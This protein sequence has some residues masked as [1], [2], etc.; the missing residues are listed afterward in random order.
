MWLRR[1]DSGGNMPVMAWSSI[2][3]VLFDAHLQSTLAAVDAA[4]ASA[5]CDT[6]VLQAGDQRLL[7]QD[8]QASPFRSNP[9]FA[10]LVPAP[11]A[12]GSLLRI[13]RGEAP[14]LLFVAPDDYWH[15]P[16]A[17][18]TSPWT[19]RFR[20]RAMASGEAALAE[21]Q[22]PTSGAAWIG[23]AAPADDRWQ[24]NPPQLLAQLEQARCRKSAYEISCLREAT[25]VA[26]AGHLAAERAFRAGRS[27]F[28]IHLAYLGAVRQ[29]DEELPYHSIIGLNEHAATLHYQLRE[30]QPPARSLSLLI[31]AGASCRGYGSDITRTWAM[32]PGTFATLVDGMHVLQQELCQAVAPGVDWRELHLTAHRLVAELLRQAGVLKISA[33]EAVERGIS[34]T[35][36]PHGLG[37]LLGVQVHDV[38]GFRATADSPPIPR[39]PGHPALRLTRKLEAGMVVTVEPGIYFID[40]LLAALRASRHADAINWTLVETLAVCGGIRIEDNVVVTAAGHDNLT[41]TAFADCG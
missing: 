6:L 12:P 30:R 28:D 19:L 26:V 11:P 13:R 40:S 15:S 37:H 31:D 41:R 21:V 16:P 17:L 32:G 20:L 23:E 4:L 38:A 27:E 24:V 25:G 36:L 9:W 8:D 1:R 35:F 5:G 29:T 34:S 33:G 10:W 18:P 7:F 14:E 3:S 39:P 2:D 22:A